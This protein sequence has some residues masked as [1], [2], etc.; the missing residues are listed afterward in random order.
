[1]P[2]IGNTT[3][4]KPGSSGYSHDPM[5]AYA[6]EFLNLTQSFLE[7]ARLDLYEEPSKVFRTPLTDETVKNFFMENSR[8]VIFANVNSVGKLPSYNLLRS[9]FIKIKNRF[10]YQRAC[11]RRHN[12]ITCEN[13]VNSTVKLFRISSSAITQNNSWMSA[14][15]L[16]FFFRRNCFRQDDNWHKDSFWIFSDLLYAFFIN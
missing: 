2:V 9:I 5:A 1:M 12:F 15:K 10:F 11:M 6:K 16:N 14:Q 13:F 8:Q 3:S 4:R 7:E